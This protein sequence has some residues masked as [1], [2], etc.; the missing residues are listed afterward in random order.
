MAKVGRKGTYQSDYPRLALVACA[1]GGFT[2]VKLAKLFDVS[3]ATINSWKQTHPEFYSSILAGKDQ[4][5]TEH[6]ETALLKRAL[7][8]QYNEITKEPPDPETGE[9]GLVITKIVRKSVPGDVKAQ[10]F[11]LRNRN[12]ERWQDKQNIAGSLSL[13]LSHEQMLDELE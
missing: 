1:E 12:G 6:V 9:T 5:D 2:D 3:R 10:T 13:T 4:Y 7:G 8:Y 11:W